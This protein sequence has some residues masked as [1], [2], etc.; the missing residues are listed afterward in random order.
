MVLSSERLISSL[1]SNSIK[2]RSKSLW[3]LTD[4][5]TGSLSCDHLFPY[6]FDV[7]YLARLDGLEV[8]CQ[9]HDVIE[10][11]HQIHRQS[12][13]GEGMFQLEV[14]SLCL[15]YL[16]VIQHCVDVDHVAHR[17][18]NQLVP[19]LAEVEAGNWQT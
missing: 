9:V 11:S 1:S 3:W 5:S 17:Q 10:Y 6:F 13:H 8:C 15:A 12:Q 18:H 16:E 14:L 19:G 7:I 2:S 4:W